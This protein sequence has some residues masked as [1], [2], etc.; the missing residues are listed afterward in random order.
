MSFKLYM[1]KHY[2]SICPSPFWV[3]IHIPDDMKFTIL[4]DVLLVYTIMYSIFL[5]MCECSDFEF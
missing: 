2:A 1:H 3:K 4:V 5:Q